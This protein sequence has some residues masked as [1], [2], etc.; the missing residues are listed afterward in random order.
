MT[1]KSFTKVL[2]Q[3]S[4]LLEQL[5]EE[6]IM[7]AAEG[8]AQL[9]LSVEIKGLS[10]KLGGTGKK[11]KA[12]SI[13]P[14]ALADRLNHCASRT[15]ALTQIEDSKFTVAQ[16]KEV[17]GLFNLPTTGNKKADLTSRLVTSVGTRADSRAIRGH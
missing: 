5:S 12:P 15:D 1:A 7:A 17:L 14:Q 6:E 9:A 11:P 3:L 2:T 13:T 10:R 16:L 8:T 4:K